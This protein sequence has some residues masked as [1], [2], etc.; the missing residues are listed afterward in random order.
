[1]DMKPMDGRPS[2]LARP[3]SHRGAGYN[4]TNRFLATHHELDADNSDLDPATE[5]DPRTQFIAD[6]SQSALTS[7]DSPDVGFDWSVNP[8]RGCEHGCAYCYARPT[9]EYLGYSAGVDFETKIL[10]KHDAP[11]L[12]R[13]EL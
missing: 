5:P 7:N 12:L 3:E 10:V 8:Y 2:S 6:H 11:E 4:P 13:R 1:M 9:H